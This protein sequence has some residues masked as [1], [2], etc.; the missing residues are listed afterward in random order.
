MSRPYLD[1]NSKYVQ[2]YYNKILDCVSDI[3]EQDFSEIEEYKVP[4][5]YGYGDWKFKVVKS[6]PAGI[7]LTQFVSEKFKQ[8]IYDN[9]VL[10][11][12]INKFGPN[13]V[14][15]EHKDPA[16]F[17]KN[18]FRIFVPLKAKDSYI[19]ANF[20]TIKCEERKPC[21]LDFIYESHSG[22]NKDPD[23][24]FIVIAFDILYETNQDYDGSYFFKGICVD[25]DSLF[26]K[27]A[28]VNMGAYQK[29]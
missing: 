6:P 10:I 9:N 11:V 20:G 3:F 14:I 2:T 25:D 8:L 28:N 17:G 21:I 29:L 23:G 26:K 4:D 24:D 12:S 5:K 19:T 27:I 7:C 16:Y 13:S 1:I 22:E 15:K 18:T